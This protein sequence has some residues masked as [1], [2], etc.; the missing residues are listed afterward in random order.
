MVLVGLM[1]IIMVMRRLEEEGGR[2]PRMCLVEAE[3][4][5]LEGSQFRSIRLV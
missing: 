1:V 4:E 2:F 3:E 5:R